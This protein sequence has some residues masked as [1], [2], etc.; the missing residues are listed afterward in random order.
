[1]L[2]FVSYLDKISRA[3]LRPRFGTSEVGANA[4][5]EMAAS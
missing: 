1:M 2:A 3:T 5:L 4:A